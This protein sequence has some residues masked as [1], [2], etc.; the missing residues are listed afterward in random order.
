[1]FRRIPLSAIIGLVGVALYLFLASSR[2]WIA[3]YGVS[4]VVGERL[5]AAVARP[6]RSAPTISAA[7]SSRG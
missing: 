4:E 1:M 6:F 5:A 7:T 2:R 3:P